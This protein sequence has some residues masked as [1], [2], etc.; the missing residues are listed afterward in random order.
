MPRWTF[1]L[2]TAIALSPKS[3]VPPA[4][5]TPTKGGKVGLHAG[6]VKALAT[7][8][9]GLQPDQHYVFTLQ[10]FQGDEIAAE[11]TLSYPD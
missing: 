1:L 7:L 2:I 8:R 6:K 11:T 10:L 9:H 4:D 3:K 5:P